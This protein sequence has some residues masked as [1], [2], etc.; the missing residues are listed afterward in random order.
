MTSNLTGANNL[1]IGSGGP[2]T[3]V[4]AGTNNT[5]S[6]TTTITAGTLQVGTGNS[7]TTWAPARSPSVSAAS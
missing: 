2:G 6:G 1:V 5:Y 7:I 4:L 3:V